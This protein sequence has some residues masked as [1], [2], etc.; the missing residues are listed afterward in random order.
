MEAKEAEPTKVRDNTM[1]TFRVVAYYRP[2]HDAAPPFLRPFHGRF[3][4]DFTTESDAFALME[5][6]EKSGDWQRIKVQIHTQGEGWD[7]YESPQRT[8]AIA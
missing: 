1:L 3:C 6:L 2:T 8:P 4:S 5:S 7:D